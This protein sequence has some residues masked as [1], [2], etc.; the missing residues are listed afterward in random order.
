MSV[1]LIRY[2]RKILP[3]LAL[4]AG[5]FAVDAQVV[6]AQVVPG[7]GTKVQ[8]VGDDFED[9]EW[10]FTHNFPKGSKEQ[11]KQTRGPTG[12]ST[13]RRWYE[14]PMRGQPDYLTRVETPEG[15]LPGSTGALLMR[16][17]RTGVP[18]YVSHKQQQ[19][20]L[21][22]NM[23]SGGI[24]HLSVS[25]TPSVVTRVY[26]PDFKQWEQRSGVSFGFRAG[27]WGTYYGN[28]YTDKEGKKVKT[29]DFDEYWPGMF[30]RL[31]PAR[32]EQ[33]T[34]AQLLIRSNSRGA[35]MPGPVIHEP[36]W[37]T[38]GMSFTPDGKI[39]YY[40]SPGVDP[41]VAEDYVTSANP[42]S[43]RCSRFSTFF[44]NVVNNDDGRSW[45]TPW[46]VDDS[47]VF[48]LR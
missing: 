44:F 46:I 6:Q 41:L 28:S 12:F 4:A 15:G 27:T 13:N 43:F 47:E 30:I 42:Y 23:R 21:V 8:N 19:D 1:S 9:P 5:M 18:S 32:G 22:A 10:G 35:D 14:G 38:L 26:I 40:A 33:P 48:V 16:S 3:L 25:R 2:G 17:L 20:D 37:W 24:G 36:G 29:G 45:S 39:H 11:D 31:N 34:T 7:T